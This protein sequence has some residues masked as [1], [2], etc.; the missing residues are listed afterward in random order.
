[1][2]VPA[3]PLGLLTHLHTFPLRAGLRR[4]VRSHEGMTRN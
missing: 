1:M 3:P 4:G 2:E